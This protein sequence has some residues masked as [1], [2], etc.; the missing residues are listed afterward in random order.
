MNEPAI[1]LFRGRGALSTGIRWF[2]RGTWS[3]AALLTREGSIVEAWQGKGV[4]ER[5]LYDWRGID[6][7]DVPGATD[8][9]WDRAIA[10]ALSQ[11]GA[12][13]DYGAIFKF[14]SRRQERPDGKWFCSE[15]V[16]EAFKNAGYP[17][18]SEW[19]ESSTVWPTMLAMSP[20]VKLRIVQ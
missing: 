9:Q 13:Y 14:L 15:L 19:V 3:H 20:L 16:Y 7:F 1:L 2:T 10:F 4:R 5:F 11:I 6:K 8:E 18:L 17:L 12:D